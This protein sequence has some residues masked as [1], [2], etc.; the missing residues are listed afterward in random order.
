MTYEINIAHQL[1]M[2]DDTWLAF[3]RNGVTDETEVELEFTYVAPGKDAA[4]ALNSS[5]ENYESVVRSDGLFRRKWYVEGKS[6]PT[7]V[8]KEKLAQWLDFMVALG[9]KHGCQFDGFGAGIPQA[10]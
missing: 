1:K 10:R 6:H 5:L 3:E 7:S 9:W 4:V 2:L 8:S